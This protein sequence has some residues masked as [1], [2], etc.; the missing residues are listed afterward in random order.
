MQ[1]S[2][3]MQGHLDNSTNNFENFFIDVLDIGQMKK[4]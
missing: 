2:D 4:F 3:R 1:R